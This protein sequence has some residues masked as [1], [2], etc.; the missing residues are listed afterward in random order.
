[1]ECRT[2]GVRENSL[3]R[4]DFEVDC[5]SHFEADFEGDCF[6]HFEAD[7]KVGCISHFEADFEVECISHFKACCPLFEVL[8]IVAKVSD[9]V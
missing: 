6:S 7:F 4:A 2:P 5:I 9:L 1:M 8:N 3:F